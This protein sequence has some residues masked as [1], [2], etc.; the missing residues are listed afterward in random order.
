MIPDILALLA[1]LA[2]ILFACFLFTNAI[3]WLGNRMKLGNGAVGSV[4]AAVGTALPETII[5]IIAVFFF[6]GAGAGQIAVGAIA[7]APFMLGTLAFFVTGAAVA[8]Y[9]LYGKRKIK[10]NASPDVI[11]RDLTFFIIVYSAA[12]LSTLLKGHGMVKIAAGITLLL[13]YIIYVKIT[14][15]DRGGEAL[16]EPEALYVSRLF[17]AGNSMPLIIIQLVVSL[18]ILVSGADFFVNNTSKL[19]LLLGVPPL[20]LSILI[21]PFATELPEKFNSVI[22]IGRNKDTLALGNITGAMVFQSCFPVVF[23]IIFTPWDIKGTTLV[24]AIFA[25]GTALLNLIWIRVTKSVNAWFLMA[26]GAVYFI[27]IAWIFIK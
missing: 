13:S 23:G 6:K 1:S 26:T 16:E 9:S 25:L 27:F 14:F 18:A 5:P 2:A 12:V 4:L 7:G 24:S 3:E 11:S 17:R 10:M 21:T 8:V 22:W 20:I 19:S 15:S